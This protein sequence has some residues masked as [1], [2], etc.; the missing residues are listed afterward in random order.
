MIANYSQWKGIGS[1]RNFCEAP[2]NDYESELKVRDEVIGGEW[3]IECI[4]INLPDVIRSKM[5]DLD[6]ATP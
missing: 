5:Y 3:N 1:L 6:P 4:S 2:L